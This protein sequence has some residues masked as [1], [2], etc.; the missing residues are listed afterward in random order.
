MKLLVKWRICLQSE[1]SSLFVKDRS[2]AVRVKMSFDFFES[3]LCLIP[4]PNLARSVNYDPKSPK[5][6]LVSLFVF[7]CLQGILKCL[8]LPTYQL[9]LG[10]CENFPC[11]HGFLV[12]YRQQP[13]LDSIGYLPVLILGLAER[14]CCL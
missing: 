11:D 3:Y 7:F 13:F 2:K 14:A 4:W 9:R 6:S 1:K 5:L 12:S 8:P 10:F